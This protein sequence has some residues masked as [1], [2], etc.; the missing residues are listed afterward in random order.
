MMLKEDRMT[1]RER[2]DALLAHRMPDRVPINMITVGFPCKNA[3]LPIAVGYSELEKYFQA[4]LWT[5]EQYGWDLFPQCCSHIVLAAADF[6]GEFRLPKGEFEG[7]PVVTSFPVNTEKD[8]EDL[9][10]PD[11]RSSD[12]INKAM[13]LS[14]MQVEHDILATFVTRSPF[15]VAA[16]L[17]GLDKFSRWMMKKPELCDRLLD[18]AINHI[19]NVLDWWVETFGPDRIFAFLTS[20]SESNQVISPKMF[21]RFALPYHLEYHRRLRDLGINRFLFHI[22]G[23]QNFNLPL[24]AEAALWPHP[25]LLSF[26]HEV[27]L[28]KAAE[29]FPEDIIYGNIDTT[30]IQMGS[31][32]EVYDCAVGIIEKGRRA[33]GGFVLSAGCELPPMVP[34]ANVFAITKAVDDFGWYV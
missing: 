10:L 25:S 34:P 14:K 8:A 31:P 12:R 9:K 22:C 28:E 21:K 24:L 3:G 33:P 29:Y 7:A 16:N 4:F 15:T 6:G 2:I 27:D 26:G 5:A 30:I 32:R 13:K 1:G 17:C 11:P 20:P 19:F 18:L 23:D